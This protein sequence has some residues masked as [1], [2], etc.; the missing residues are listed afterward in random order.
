MG[1]SNFEDVLG[2]ATLLALETSTKPCHFEEEH[3]HET[4]SEA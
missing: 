4:K 1:N 2:A 3:I